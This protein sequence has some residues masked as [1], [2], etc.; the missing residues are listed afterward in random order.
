[1]L[2]HRVSCVEDNFSKEQAAG[3]R[4]EECGVSSMGAAFAATPAPPCEGD[5]APF[6]L[7]RN[8]IETLHK[9]SSDSLA[10][11]QGQSQADVKR[12]E[13]HL[14]AGAALIRRKQAIFLSGIGEMARQQARQK[15][16]CDYIAKRQ[17]D[18][19]TLSTPDSTTPHR[20][21]FLSV[22]GLISAEGQRVRMR[23]VPTTARSVQSVSLAAGGEGAV[24]RNGGELSARHTPQAVS[25]CTI[26]SA[27][28]PPKAS[29]WQDDHLVEPYHGES[30]GPVIPRQRMMRG[31]DCSAAGE[32]DDEVAG[33]TTV[34]DGDGGY[35]ADRAAEV[36]SC[37]DGN[38]ESMAGVRSGAADGDHLM[39]SY[40]KMLIHN[41]HRHDAVFYDAFFLD[42]G[43]ITGG[44]R[45][46]KLIVL[47]S[48]RASVISFV[49]KKVLKKDIN[50]DFYVQHP[51]LEIREIKLTHMRAIRADLLNIV[52]EEASPIELATVAY[53][54]W[55][56]ERLIVRGM[57][58]KR[59]RRLVLAVALLLAIK[60]VETGD[61][62]R[63]IHYLKARIR[64]DDAFRGVSWQKVQQWEFCAYVGLEFTLLPPRGSRVVETHMDRLLTQVNVTSQEYYSKKFAWP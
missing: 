36:G 57:V 46:K 5:L 59:N 47:D 24:K 62:H 19:S 3:D 61:V 13:A 38:F 48:Y 11:Q 49:D 18:V 35:I 60:F 53:A 7:E 14:R 64:H 25:L 21:A 27:F 56:F 30:Y 37:D 31:D 43:N 42:K 4:F 55:Y 32:R 34:A 23:V 16:R 10:S 1:M 50:S 9:N 45:R 8:S 41:D 29:Y 63:K 17:A 20:A 54:N 44:E 40:G 26:L 2:S 51:E 22:K 33:G 58:G 39:R 28:E 6:L 52:L 12:Q 15:K